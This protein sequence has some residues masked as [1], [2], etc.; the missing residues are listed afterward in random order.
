MLS[1]LSQRLDMP[2]IWGPTADPMW[3]NAILSRYPVTSVQVDAMPNNTVVRPMRGYIVTTIDVGG[4]PLQVIA[5]HLHHVG[6]DGALRIPQVQAILDTWNHQPHTA[7]LGDFNAEPDST[8]MMLMR[9]AGLLDSFT[10]ANASNGGD[11]YMSSH[12]D[13]R[14]DYIYITPDLTPTRFHVNPST[15]S[16]HLAIAV[17]IDVK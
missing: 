7:I 11:T 17:T 9:Q 14:I 16:D 10:V 5:T 15:A 6:A 3:G 4:R 8:E 12:P 1:W 13:R 2:Y